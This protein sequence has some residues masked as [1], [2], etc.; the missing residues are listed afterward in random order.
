MTWLRVQFNCPISCAT[1]LA[2]RVMHV[3]VWQLK[4]R[5]SLPLSRFSIHYN[6]TDALC[7]K[8]SVICFVYWVWFSRHAPVDCD[9]RT[10]NFCFQREHT[11][12]VCVSY[13]QAKSE[14]KRN[15]QIFCIVFIHFSIFTRNILTFLHSICGSIES[16]KTKISLY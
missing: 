10:V 14:E 6:L 15:T 13:G 11:R 8:F 5:C 4:I 2:V 12:T 1:F 9:Q 3:L 7:G 16:Q